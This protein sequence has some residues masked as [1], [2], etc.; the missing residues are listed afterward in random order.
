M[1]LPLCFCYIRDEVALP[2]LHAHTISIH[3]NLQS[4]ITVSLQ[5]ASMKLQKVQ[6]FGS[7]GKAF[8]PSLQ[9]IRVMNVFST[10]SEGEF[11]HDILAHRHRGTAVF[12]LQVVCKR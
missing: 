3:L 4:M 5:I 7:G 12:C 10:S 8:K 11:S 1:F 6:V 9:I 2:C